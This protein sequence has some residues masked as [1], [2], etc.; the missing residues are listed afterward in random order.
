MEISSAVSAAQ[1]IGKADTAAGGLGDT[2]DT[3]L[4][5]LTTQLQHQDPLSPMESNEF[6]KQLVDFT[7]VE[8]TIQTNK[9]LETLI[10]LSFANHLTSG[11]N[12]L[13]KEVT[14]NGNTTA[15]SNGSA[16]WNF[17]LQQAAA[18]TALV[19]TDE[20]GKVVFT[21]SGDTKAGDQQFVWDGTANDGTA[22]PD[23]IYSMQVT[24][25]D[26]AGNFVGTSTT[27]DGLV[28]GV[29]IVEGEPVLLVNGLK[30]FL[31]EILNVREP[32]KET[33]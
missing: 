19:V 7:G 33:I 29:E 12:Y 22:L 21:G 6:T 8:Q 27:I 30:I 31:S 23:G 13:G 2:F 3:F 25:I 28:E 18:S 16:T 1:N 9:N 24:A 17:N 10:G 4:V 11:V 14:A 32:G 5:L 26:A 20:S 15:L